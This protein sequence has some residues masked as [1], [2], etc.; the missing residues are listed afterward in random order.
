VTA[1]PLLGREAE[2]RSVAEFLATASTTPSALVVEGKPG[3]GKT[4]L[5]LAGVEQAREHG[6]QVLSARPAAAESAL[7]Y[8]SLADL[9][10]GVEAAAQ[11][12][13]PDPQ[14]VALEHV[15]LRADA[16]EAPTDPRAVS[17]ALLSVVQ[18]LAIESPVLVAID[19]LQWLDM[20]S[21]HAIAFALRRLA[22]RVA[23]LATTRN[24]RDSASA[25]SWLQLPTPDAIRR[26]PLRP[27]NISDL[28]AVITE[29]LGQSF[30]RPAML[31]IHEVS[32]GNPFY[33]LELARSLEGHT[34][35]PTSLPASLAELVRARVGSLEHDVRQALLAVACFAV[36]T[37]ELVARATGN[38][39][40]D[41]VAL[42]AGAESTGIVEIDGVYLRFTHPLLA[43]GVYTDTSPAL[44]RAMHQRLAGLVEDPE[45]RARHL[46]L[47]ATTATPAT[48]E[49]LDVAAELARKRGA[50][51]AAAELLD[52]GLALG[53]HTPERQIR[54]ASHHLGAGNPGRAKN[55]LEQAI[56][57]SAPG[58]LRARALVQLAVVN[59]F[60]DGLQEGAALF[61]R[62]LGEVGGDFALRAQILVTLSF[63][64]L[65]EDRFA[66]AVDEKVEEAVVAARRS[67]VPS[68]V[69][70][71]LGARAMIRFIQGKGHDQPGMRR[72]LELEDPDANIAIVF[73]P[74]V[75]NA[76]LAGWSGQ[77]DNARGALV[78][79]G[80]GCLE[81]GEES[82]LVYLSFHT[83]L[84]EFWLGEFIEAGRRAE[85]TV[86]RARRLGG[87]IPLLEALTMRALARSYAGQEVDA[88]SD[89]A[90]A[91]AASARSGMHAIAEWPVTVLGF[92][93]MSLGNY[94]AA[95]AALTPLMCKITA[96]LASTEIIAGSF[97]PDAVEA[98]IHLDRLHDAE[99]LIDLLEGNGRRLDRPWM[100]AVGGRCRGMLLAARGD[101]DG[102][103]R[104][105]DQAMVEH[106]RIPMPFERART[107]L[108]LG[109]I[110]RRQRQEQAATASLTEAWRVF[111]RLGTPLWAAR[112]RAERNR[113]ANA[114][115]RPA[116]T[117]AEQ[118]V[119]RLTASGMTNGEVAA[120]LFISPK[121]VEF[122]LAGT[123]RKLG[124]RSRAELGAH[125]RERS[126]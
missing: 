34:L 57:H 35:T 70:Q 41:L 106:D 88:R 16:G 5:W 24:D 47:A 90:E 116:L 108:L 55:L 104:A 74:T 21:A 110:Q 125:M 15:L 63:A 26:I 81:R 38:G 111:E 11:S 25:T 39:A 1:S 48:L 51:A 95:L 8:S 100:L 43:R 42:L 36:P 58:A 49:S 19:D 32:G 6:F 9:L 79:I 10:G 93:E 53:G 33:A 96:T 54:A 62:A 45:S 124:I 52:L 83:C 14:R 121:T 114:T 76:L 71:A 27:L 68:L 78:S 109:G 103:Y 37:V 75:Q 2:T 60:D 87:D 67:G 50:P 72:A 123:Y 30:P 82:E 28:H 89:L 31:K 12:D 44:R 73:R 22:G 84:V 29:R 23:V 118:K 64:L 80:R 69:S 119:A 113:A 117:S 3:I 94:E 107:Q 92:L 4:T 99:P 126:D 101:I 86:E 85:D 40:A 120:A 112:A 13:L 61:E 97:I 17:A 77:L 56:A 59:L 91:T 18:R 102:A 7:S 105:T 65:N 122:H 20:S 98:L 66:E 115:R 46:A